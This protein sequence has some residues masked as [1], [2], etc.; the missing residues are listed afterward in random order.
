[1]ISSGPRSGFSTSTSASVH[2]F[3]F[4]CRRLEERRAGRRHRKGLV[5]FFGFLLADGVGE[6]E[7]ELIER[8]LQ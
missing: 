1:M 4:G 7:S 3:R 2:G 5:E 6:A 8:D